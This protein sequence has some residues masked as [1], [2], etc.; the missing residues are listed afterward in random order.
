[1]GKY[2][3]NLPEAVLASQ[4][5]G[6]LELEERFGLTGGDIF[7]G[8]LLPE[9]SFGARFPYRTPVPGLYLCGSGAS[10][11]GCVMGAAGRNAAATVLAD[12]AS[13]KG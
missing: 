3:P 7:H 9:Q 5:L 10:P 1:L 2:A 12:P 6:P 13:K 11:G 8:A 4:V